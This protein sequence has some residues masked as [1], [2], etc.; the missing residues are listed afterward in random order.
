MSPLSLLDLGTSH[1]AS[2]ERLFAGARLLASAVA[3][4]VEATLHDRGARTVRHRLETL[5]H[6]FS[7][8]RPTPLTLPPA[9]RRVLDAWEGVAATALAAA[10]ATLAADLAPLWASHPDTVRLRL[11]DLL[12]AL[13]RRG[14]RGDPTGEV[15][16][17]LI[18][19]AL[20]VLGLRAWRDVEILVGDL[21]H[22][23]VLQRDIM[24]GGARLQAGAA[25]VCGGSGRLWLCGAAD[26]PARPGRRP[27]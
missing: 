26:R 1:T 27:P 20:G 18:P 10:L 5:V 3:A 24:G 2:E 12:M 4:R 22:G 13:A 14:A 25:A 11:L 17:A 7:G 21:G 19:A 8:A 23:L 9:E 16:A 6:E 15:R